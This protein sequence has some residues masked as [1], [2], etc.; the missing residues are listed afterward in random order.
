MNINQSPQDDDE[1]A[2]V[3]VEAPGFKFSFDPDDGWKSIG[4]TLVLVLGVVAGVKLILDY[5]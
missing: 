2:Q 4:M 3:T 5:L 1:K